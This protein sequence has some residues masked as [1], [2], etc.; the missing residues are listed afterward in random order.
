MKRGYTE[1]VC[2][3]DDVSDG[4]VTRLHFEGDSLIVQRT[5]DAEP[6]LARAKLMRDCQDGKPW[7]Q[8]RHIG[9]IPP[10]EYARILKLPTRAARQKAVLAFLREN[11]AFV[12]FSRFL[13]R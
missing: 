4:V 10:A 5:Y 9:H 1:N 11:P 13:K 6:H 8:G 12:G 2:L 7:G 3:V